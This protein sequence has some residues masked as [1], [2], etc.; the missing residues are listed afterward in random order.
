MFPVRLKQTLFATAILTLAG[1][2]GQ[3]TTAMSPANLASH[4]VQPAQIQQIQ[5][6]DVSGDTLITQKVGIRLN[7][8]T[9]FNSPNYGRVLGYFKG[10]TSTISQVVKVTAAEPIFFFNVDAS[11]PHTASFLGNATRHSAPWPSSLNGSGTQSPAGTVISTPMFST[12][13]LNHGAKSLKYK[14]GSPGFFM[15]GCAFHYDLDGMR[16]VIVVQ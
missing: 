4:A 7:G 16:T 9:P 5:T 1:C 8:E 14:T 13:T 12:G 2:S 6:L 11:A 3:G 10:K 15:F